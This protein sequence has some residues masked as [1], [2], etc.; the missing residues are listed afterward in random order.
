MNIHSDRLADYGLSRY[1]HPTEEWLDFV[2]LYPTQA[3]D[4]FSDNEI[5]CA[6]ALRQQ[7]DNSRSVASERLIL[8]SWLGDRV[9]ISTLLMHPQAAHE[10]PLRLYR[11]CRSLFSGPA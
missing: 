1:S 3:L 4:S 10:I 8:E 5:S 6:S 9:T 2:Q 11:P 7:S